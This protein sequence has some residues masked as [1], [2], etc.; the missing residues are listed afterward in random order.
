[1][2]GK[3]LQVEKILLN[4]TYVGDDYPAYIIGEISGNHGGDLSTALHLIEQAKNMGVNA[5]KLQTYT[6]DTITINSDKEDFK[7]PDSS[8]WKESKTLH[9][10]YA[11]AYT[12]WE[13]HKKLFEKARQLEIDI[14]SSPF[15][16]T[17]VDFLEELEAPF[18]KIASPEIVDL[19]LLKKVASTGKPVIL[20]TG[21]AVLE[22]IKL[23]I[24][25]LN[26]HGCEDIVLLKCSTSY[27]AKFE[28]VNLLT[29]ED[30]KKK[31]DVVIG[32]SDHT[33]GAAVPIAAVAL[34]A[35]VIEKHFVNKGDTT[36]D[37]FFSLEVESFK[38]M[39]EDIRKVEKSLGDINYDLTE[40]VKENVWAKR[41]LYVSKNVKKGEILKGNI[42]SVRPG[43]GL[44]PM[45]FD[46]VSSYFATKDLEI[47]DR[48]TWDVITRD[49]NK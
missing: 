15:D 44:H 23:A 13:W 14:F 41:S 31:F 24:N 9:S 47:G 46:E 20:S 26:E 8:P 38:N 43:Y 29:M 32:I 45:Y 6:A 39:I 34:G 40:S 21:L 48:V 36:V 4:K 35:K 22:D 30:Y 37:S 28:E 7:I 12:P 18:Y 17:A 33:E 25:T 1:M 2:D 10:L 49:I 5:V 3:Y 42:K 19:N 27:P 16:E 11:E